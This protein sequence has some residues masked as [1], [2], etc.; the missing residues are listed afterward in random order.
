MNKWQ[1]YFLFN[2][3]LLTR[4]WW[5]YHE[6]VQ[7]FFASMPPQFPLRQPTPAQDVSRTDGC[8]GIAPQTLST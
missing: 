2:C 7:L 4:I 5:I 1:T 8:C 3:V 6:N